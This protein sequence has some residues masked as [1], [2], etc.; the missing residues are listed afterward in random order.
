MSKHPTAILPPLKVQL[1][2]TRSGGVKMLRWGCTVSMDPSSSKN[3][4]A[5]TGRIINPGEHPRLPRL[6]RSAFTSPCSLF[7][8]VIGP[9]HLPAELSSQRHIL[10]SMRIRLSPSASLTTRFLYRSITFLSDPGWTPK[11]GEMTL[12]WIVQY[13]LSSSNLRAWMGS[14]VNFFLLSAVIPSHGRRCLIQ[15]L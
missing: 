10:D 4:H 13:A 14:F 3:R 9:G 7:P 12:A 11:G 5:I 15:V 1:Q 8:S 6:P 2:L